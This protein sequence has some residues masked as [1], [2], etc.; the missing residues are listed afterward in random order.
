MKLDPRVN[1]IQTRL[2]KIKKIIAVSG[3]K[4]GVGKSSI[5]CVLSLLLAKQGGASSLSTKKVG[6]MDL[7]LTGN[8]DNTILGIKTQYPEEEHGVQPVEENGIKFISSYFYS[9]GKATHFR[10]DEISNILL[11]LFAITDW[12]ELDYL[13][14][15]MPPGLSDTALDII[16]WI[17]QAE[18]LAI[19]TPSILS[20]N[21]VAKS[22]KLLK[23][24][25]VEIIGFVE[26]MSDGK[27][28]ELDGLKI[29]GSIPKD[30]NFEQAIGD[31]DKLLETNFAKALKQIDGF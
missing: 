15:D 2:S 28:R 3:F 14:L 29:L 25:K 31:A 26:N 21:L 6:L 10:G 23:E 13:I 18:V 22:A 27:A 1:I 9:Q 4:G 8:C 5:A 16:R 24:Q 30:E 19:S 7:D 20:R 17:P 11:E 12:G